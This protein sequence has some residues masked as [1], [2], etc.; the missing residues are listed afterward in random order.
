MTR[1]APSEVNE[2]RTIGVSIYTVALTS[3]IAIPIIVTLSDLPVPILAVQA[4]AVW[5][6]VT[7]TLCI[8]FVPKLFA[9][10]PTVM[11]VP[12][13]TARKEQEMSNTSYSDSK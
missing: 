12:V 1:N 6:T 11:G 4:V 7:S 2:S 10:E 9:S 5:I 13:S 8:L 3:V